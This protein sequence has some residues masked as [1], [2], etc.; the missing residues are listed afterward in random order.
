MVIIKI[1]SRNYYTCL[2]CTTNVLIHAFLVIELSKSICLS[3]HFLLCVWKWNLSQQD[4]H[5]WYSN[6]SCLFSRRLR[7]LTY[8]PAPENL[9]ILL[10]VSPFLPFLLSFTPRIMLYIMWFPSLDF[11]KCGIM[12]YFSF[13]VWLITTQCMILQDHLYYCK[14]RWL[15]FQYE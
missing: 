8:P 14:W 2:K 7:L 13:C 11:T 10:C 12:G 9:N 3:P 5:T 4:C 1:N 15:I 6:T